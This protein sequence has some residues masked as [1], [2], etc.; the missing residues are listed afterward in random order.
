MMHRL[1]E[2]SEFSGS[3]G[4]G[5]ER[6]AS[7]SSE[8][9]AAT[10]ADS[11]ASHQD[12]TV[13][14]AAVQSVLPAPPCVQRHRSDLVAIHSGGADT[15]GVVGPALEESQWNFDY[16]SCGLSDASLDDAALD[17][18]GPPPSHSWLQLSYS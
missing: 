5:A 16:A 18:A 15:V 10:H 7:S 12:D 1:A 17:D 3:C 14:G 13:T 4:F 2:S 6:A 9:R 11:S 8:R